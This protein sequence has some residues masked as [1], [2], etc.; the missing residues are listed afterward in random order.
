M[1][2]DIAHGPHLVGI[3]IMV[4][5]ENGR[6]IFAAFLVDHLYSNTFHTSYYILLIMFYRRRI[7]RF[8]FSITKIMYVDV[9]LSLS[10]TVFFFFFLCNGISIQVFA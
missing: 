1:S 2:L 9:T 7:S 6:E 5:V 8:K 10:L 3:K 4:I